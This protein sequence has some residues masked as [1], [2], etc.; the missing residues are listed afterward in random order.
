MSLRHLFCA[1]ALAIAVAFS[2]PVLADAGHGYD[3][4]KPAKA[5]QATRTVEINLG[6]MY[7]E[8]E[9]LDIKA[10][11]TVRFVIHNKGSLLHEFNLGSAAMHA[12]HQKEMQQM[13]DSGMLTPT[14]MQ[15]DMSKMDHSKM[16][17][18]NMPMGQMMKHDDP[19]SVLVE[20]GKTAEL[21]WTFNK[22]TSLEFACNVPG[23]YQAGMVGKLNVKP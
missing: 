14:G 18:G 9:S 2:L 22:A 16:G 1:S 10:G 3:F 7:F 21:T 12:G 20:P 5:D 19:N 6:E 17:H 15:H 8:P 11:E 23:H 13:M 4:G